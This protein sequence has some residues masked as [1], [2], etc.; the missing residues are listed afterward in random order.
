[1]EALQGRSSD[2]QTEYVRSWK[3]RGGKVL[4]YACV[5]TPV[6]IIEAAGILPYRIKAFGHPDTELGDSYLAR[7]N[8]RFCRSCLQLGLDGTYDFLDGLIETNGCDHLRGMFENWQYAKKYEF[9][10]YLKVPHFVR[11]DSLEYF[12]EEL[13]LLK[14]AVEE[15]FGVEITDDALRE[16]VGTMNQVQARLKDL[17]AL[18]EEEKPRLSGAETLRVICTGSSMRAAD[19]LFLL[20]RLVEEK[21]REP[22]MEARA[23]LLLLGSATDEVGL[24]AEIEDQGGLVVA[25]ALCY[26]SRSF[27]GREGESLE[28]PL[29]YLAEKYLGNLFCPRMFMEYERRRDFILDRAR[30]AGVDGAIITYNKFCDLHGVEAVS[31]RSDLENNGI[32]VLVLE[33]DYGSPADA[34]RIRTR[35]QAFLER[36]GGRTAERVEATR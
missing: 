11:R 26:G 9:F 23:R 30:Q 14:L 35:V 2:V 1:M 24:V 17:Y 10:H 13:S 20:D 6:E 3:E 21:S 16:A 27:W 29:R 34:G 33:K 15:H 8:C 5:A 7:F 28:E 32:P 19:F 22:G 36:I 4:G 18:R 25:D 31:L 12:T